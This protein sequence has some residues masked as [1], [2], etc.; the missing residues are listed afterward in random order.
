MNRIEVLEQL[1]PIAGLRVQTITHGPRTRFQ[2]TPEAMIFNPGDHSR[3][4]TIPETAGKQMA[5]FAPSTFSTVMT[6][7]LGRREQYT[8]LTREGELV[9]TVKAG[10]YQNLSSERV[11]VTIEKAVGE[12]LEFHRVGIM[13]NTT[14]LLEIVGV[15][16]KPVIPGDLVR[17]GALVQFSPIS[18]VAPTVQSYVVRRVC[19]NGATSN[20]VLDKFT[21]GGDN[22]D[23]WKWLRLSVRKAY[24]SVDR[25]VSRWQELIAEQ[26]NP[27]DRAAAME[28][29]IKEM[30]LDPMSAE[31]MRAHALEAPPAN[32]FELHQL[33]TWTTSHVVQDERIR[34]R[35]MNTSAEFLHATTHRRICP[36]CRRGAGLVP[37][38]PAPAEAVTAN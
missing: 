12:G 3:A 13:G 33:A 15:E 38:L 23:F 26:I 28:A 32:S 35:A 4:I 9:E 7:M 27:Q 19:T 1:Q 16:E 6:E 36:V 2:V 30:R 5:K 29:L 18:I 31:S 17:A 34:V 21:G 8:L 14:A 11:L 37:A 24:R 10:Q 22:G 20:Y 25:I